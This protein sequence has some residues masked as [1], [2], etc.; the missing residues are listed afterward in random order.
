M[1]AAS[2]DAVKVSVMSDIVLWPR[3]MDRVG[4]IPRLL[5]CALLA[6]LL[7]VSSAQLLT[8]HSVEKNGM[9]QAEHALEVS[10]AVLRHELAALGTEWRT[11]QEGTLLLG[12][13]SLNGR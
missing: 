1:P 7:A 13:S 2:T 11:T 9:Q 5:L 12:T 4:I 6:I 3:L 10:M 8:L